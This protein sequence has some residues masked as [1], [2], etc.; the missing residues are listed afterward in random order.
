M[1]EKS[2]QALKIL[3]LPVIA[4]LIGTAIYLQPHSDI[5]DGMKLSGVRL[6]QIGRFSQP[7]FVTQ[8]QGES[9]K[10]FVVE[11]SGKVVVLIDGRQ[12]K[13]PF[14]DIS[15]LV[16]CCGERGLLGL[17]FDPDYSHNRLLYVYYTNRSGDTR[18]VEYQRSQSNPN[19]VEPSSARLVLAQEQPQPNHNGGNILFGP[20]GFLYIGLGDGGGRDDQHGAF[21]NAQNR[22]SLLGKIL[23]ISPHRLGSLA[24]Q[25]PSTNPWFGQAG[26]RT[27]VW[28]YGLRNPWRFSFDRK[29]GGLVIGDVGQDHIEEVNWSPAPVR[30]KGANYGWRVYEGTQLYSRGESAPRA[31]APVAQYSH[32]DGNCSITGGYVIRDSRI[33]S[34][35]GKYLFGDFCSGR[36]WSAGL[37]VG[38]L[39]ASTKM[40]P[41]KV[42][43]LSSFGEDEGGRVYLMSLS[44]GVVYRLDPS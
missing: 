42:S 3:V 17:A 7:V 39:A 40:L 38:K 10:L 27:E 20:D 28:S 16:S 18:V 21:G 4:L 31:V 30:G 14:L 24:Y 6:T 22:N 23:R 19:K 26:V 8:P 43:G 12:Q 29:T 2:K 44:T 41:F 35:Y 9:H 32:S 33:S 5:A 25:V 34:L 15:S 1:S 36:L 37:K 11:Q 13:E